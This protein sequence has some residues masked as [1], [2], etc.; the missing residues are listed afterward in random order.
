MDDVKTL[1][2]DR[3]LLP[4]VLHARDLLPLLVLQGKRGSSRDCGRRGREPDLIAYA[5]V[6]AGLRTAASARAFGS[7][8]GPR[9]T[10]G[11][12]SGYGVPLAG[13]VED[14]LE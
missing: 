3:C 4:C 2:S 7:S 5:R 10:R 6:G 13:R 8:P 12:R 1:Q 14:S 11:L 9:A